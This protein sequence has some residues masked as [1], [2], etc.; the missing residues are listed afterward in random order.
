MDS[1]A[2]AATI[3]FR[4]TARHAGATARTTD[5]TTA[6]TIFRAHHPP[7]RTDD[8]GKRKLR[9]FTFTR[10]M[11]SSILRSDYQIGIHSTKY[12]CWAT[13]CT[14]IGYTLE[15]ECTF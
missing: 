5:S 2:V 4:S 14:L 15:I 1:A 7:W 12:S 10:S 13:W 8:L 11:I 3:R 6:H 9:W